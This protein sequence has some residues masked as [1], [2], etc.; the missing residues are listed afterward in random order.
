[1]EAAALRAGIDQA[2]AIDATAYRGRKPSYDRSALS[3]IIAA[4]DSADPPSLGQLAKAFNISK[5][6]AFRISKDRMGANGRVRCL[7]DMD[8]SVHVPEARG[9]SLLARKQK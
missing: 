8:D 7:G 3:S 5:Q 2:R 9:V 1:V 4:L 6:T